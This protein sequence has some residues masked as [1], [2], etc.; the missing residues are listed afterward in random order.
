[1]IVRSWGGKV[2]SFSSPSVT[3]LRFRIFYFVVKEANMA[4]DPVT[5]LSYVK[6]DKVSKEKSKYKV[7]A[8]RMS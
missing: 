4:N 7:D 8:R 5:S 6:R 3:T 1:M 2:H